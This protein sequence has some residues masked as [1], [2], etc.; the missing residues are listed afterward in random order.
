MF[1]KL[2]KAPKRKTP[3]SQVEEPKTKQTHLVPENVWLPRLRGVFAVQDEIP[4]LRCLTAT[5]KSFRAL[6][7]LLFS[8]KYA[9]SRDQAEALLSVLGGYNTFISGSAGTGKTHLVNLIRRLLSK[10]RK[11]E[12]TTTTGITAVQLG[13]KTIHSFSGI[14]IRKWPISPKLLQLI[15]TDPRVV[16]RW[17]GVNTLLIDEISMLSPE[18]FE[19]CARI[20]KFIRHVVHY[21]AGLQLI[22]IG[23]FLQLPPINAD[24][25]YNSAIWK[26]LK[27]RNHFL[28]T[29]WRQKNN[30]LFGILQEVR[31]GRLSFASMLKL[32][33]RIG[34]CPDKETAV[35]AFSR[36]DRT[37]AMNDKKFAEI[38]E[39]E[40]SYRAVDR[41]YQTKN[42]VRLRQLPLGAKD[43]QRIDRNVMVSSTLKLKETCRVMAVKNDEFG[44]FANG[45]TGTVM[46]MVDHSVLVQFDHREEPVLVSAMDFEVWDNDNLCIRKQLPFILA[47]AVT[48]HK[49]QGMTIDHLH[50]D[51]SKGTMFASGQAYV[52]LSRCR[53]LEGLCLKGFDRSAIFADPATV[54]YYESVFGK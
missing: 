40:R 48:I 2:Y 28:T 29:P 24:Y 13:C 52:F 9:L 50:G 18:Q 16:S 31:F 39:P 38:D 32:K 6:E 34:K 27:F 25:L 37:K 46:A 11:L 43:T 22:T 54:E 17:W 45:S 21:F 44:Y 15:A 33:E 41:K 36:R 42:G 51:L 53:S 12:L 14:G 1:S 10:Y 7:P 19:L 20:H 8:E 4:A 23:D 3:E 35:F 49:T 26:E 47:Y 30:T 5:C